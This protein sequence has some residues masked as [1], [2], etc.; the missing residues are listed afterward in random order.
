MTVDDNLRSFATPR[1]LEIIDAIEKHGSHRKAAKALGVSN[2]TIG[3]AI[4]GLKRRA[5]KMGYAPGH[6]DHGVAP[7]YRMGK[8]TV[9]RGPDG[10][11]RVWERQHPEAEQMEAAIRATIEAMKEELPRV[12]PIP[13]PAALDEHLCN[14]YT[15]TD[16][17]VGMLASAK[18]TLDADWDLKIAERTLT[19]AFCHMVNASPKASIG[20]V[21]QLGDWLHSDGSNGMLPVTPL[22]QNVLDQDGRFSKIVAASIRILRRIIDFALERHEK[23]IVLMAEGNH[24]MASSVWLRAMFAALY[25]NEPRVQVIDSAL[26]YYVYQH[27]ETM[28]A[29]HHG[30]LKKNDDLPLLFAAQFPKV[31]GSTVKRYCSTGHR[32]HIEEKEHSGMVVIQH[33]TLAARD[34]Y[35]ARGGWLSERS[36]T[37]ISYH[38]KYGQVAR[39]TVCP[40]MFESA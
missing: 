10:V 35:A 40:E 13:A 38:S 23:V 36:A 30:H 8:V 39:N 19:A 12:K 11:E 26:P 17:H 6:W 31:W 34:A 3:D 18:E 2:G 25:E 21:A 15:L 28:L 22:H 27:G 1:Q 32:H 24:D 16:C 29:F 37:A 7:G 14:V 33:P 9:Q 4:V 5:A 20:V